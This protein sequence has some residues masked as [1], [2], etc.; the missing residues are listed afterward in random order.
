MR[1]KGSI[2]MDVIFSIMLTLTIIIFVEASVKNSET[3]SKK[4]DN[5]QFTKRILIDEAEKEKGII[6]SY[7]GELDNLSEKVSYK[8]GKYEV[9]KNRKVLDARF[10][11]IC[12]QIKVKNN[13]TVEKIKVYSILGED[14]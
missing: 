8:D 11:Y 13:A 6:S 5:R 3:I 14:D 10:G 1:R 7:E 2:G 4:M 9:E 12:S